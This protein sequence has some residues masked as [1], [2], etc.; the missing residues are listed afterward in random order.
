MTD[1]RLTL[2]NKWAQDICNAAQVGALDN[3]KAIT[4]HSVET[5]RGPR[6]GA[7]EIH[8][9]MDTGRLLAV[10]S[11]GDFS[12]HR[13]FVPW[14]FGGEPSVYLTSRYVRLEAAWPDDL[15]EKNITLE[16]IGQYPK[17]GGRWIA[18]KNEVG[19]TVTLGVSD[20]VP[21][22]LFGGW[23]GSGKTWALRS[24][25]AQ[26]SRDPS[27]RLVL[28][29][30]KF[31][32]GLGCLGHL[33]GLA[34]P[35]A[36]DTESARGALSWAVRELRRRYEQHDRRGRVIVCI[37]EIQ[38]FTG[39]S[40]DALVTEFVRKL[41]TQGRGAGVY[42][43]VG[44][45]HP[46]GDVFSDST[47]RRNLPGRVALRTE[48]AKASEVVIGGATP[49]AD[50]LLGA[51]DS[52]IVTPSAT[53]RAQL[54]YIPPADL[55][56]MNTSQPTMTTWPEPDPEAAG[57]LPAEDAA[58]W[59]YS[60]PELAVSLVNAHEGK[61]RP[62]LIKALE[63]AQMGRP[64]KERAVRLLGLG[65]DAYEWLTDNGYW[66]AGCQEDT[67]AIAGYVAQNGCVVS[68]P[69]YQP[70]SQGEGSFE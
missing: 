38:E 14:H 30:G 50:R 61:G 18:G 62:A 11:R 37:D 52:Y 67:H 56:K 31:G 39:R 12:L 25:L 15:A 40:G 57:S 70:A 27:N 24:A 33:P 63:A 66:L 35:V 5:V 64:G 44:T 65:R 10:L 22:Y 55:E 58:R 59:E 42:L 41:A 28:V 20:T 68:A 43:F 34:G 1:N 29:D 16:S 49:R 26:L 36:I 4:I 51:G 17:G 46:V 23:T 53:R 6:A 47:I 13:Q 2:L 69:N 45:Q 8:A 60:G 21:H 32:D 19:A 7:L 9:G 48:N 54:A 3:G